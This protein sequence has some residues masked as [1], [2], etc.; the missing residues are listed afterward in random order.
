VNVRQ[1]DELVELA[2]VRLG[3]AGLLVEGADTDEVSNVVGRSFSE[4]GE[5]MYSAAMARVNRVLAVLN[6]P[7]RLPHWNWRR[8][9]LGDRLTWHVYWFGGRCCTDPGTWEKPIEFDCI[10]D[11]IEWILDHGEQFARREQQI[12]FPEGLPKPIEEQS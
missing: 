7:A 1:I 4:W 5:V 2:V 12:R 3:L 11:A 10:G 9:L 6:E 8:N